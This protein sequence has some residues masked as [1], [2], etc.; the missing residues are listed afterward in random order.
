MVSTIG[1]ESNPSFQ[2]LPESELFIFKYSVTCFWWYMTKY[3]IRTKYFIDEASYLF[4]WSLQLYESK[5]I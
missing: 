4:I 2:K 1:S 5:Y 3:F